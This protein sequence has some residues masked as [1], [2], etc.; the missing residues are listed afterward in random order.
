MS[1]TDSSFNGPAAASSRVSSQ[2]SELDNPLRS[3]TRG[4]KSLAEAVKSQQAP[5]SQTKPKSLKLELAAM[6]PSRSHG[7]SSLAALLGSPAA[8]PGTR[9]GSGSSSS[10]AGAGAGA[11]SGAAAASAKV[12]AKS[13]AGFK[14]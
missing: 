2:Q 10:S 7:S 3:P 14:F 8:V 5:T 4:E 9:A 12:A 13:L 11:G 1:L 6:T